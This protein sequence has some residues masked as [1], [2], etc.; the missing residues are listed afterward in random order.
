MK[1][2]IGIILV[3]TLGG[4]LLGTV[5][6]VVQARPMAVALPST[7][8]YK[9]DAGVLDAEVLD[10]GV[11]DGQ[12][13]KAPR[14]QLEETVYNFGSMEQGTSLS[15]AFKVRNVGGSPLSIEVGATTCKCTVGG[16]STREVGPDEEAEVTLSFRKGAWRSYQ[17]TYP[18]YQ[19]TDFQHFFTCC[20]EQVS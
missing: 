3:G 15:H 6:A 11:R 9:L 5:L 13:K 16:L 12:S 7:D 19:R 2:T 17:W 10:A 1:S 18:D 20:R 14:A 8:T 4:L